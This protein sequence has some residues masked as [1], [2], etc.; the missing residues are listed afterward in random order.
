[1]RLDLNFNG[2]LIPIEQV[3]QIANCY[4]RVFHEM[5]EHP[6]TSHDVEALFSRFEAVIVPRQTGDVSEPAAAEP[7]PVELELKTQSVVLPKT[8]ESPHLDQAARTPME[9]LL[10]SMWSHV[11]KKERINP[12][13]NFFI[14]GGDSLLATQLM[15][16]VRARLKID[17]PLPILFEE[18]PTLRTFAGK[19]EEALRSGASLSR[20]PIEPVPRGQTF[21]LSFAQRRLWFVEHLEPTAYNVPAAIR[22][23][24]P[25][26]RPALKRSLN[27]IVRRHESL[28]TTFHLV[29]G[30]PVQRIA[31]SLDIDVPVVDLSSSAL[32]EE[33]SGI[34]AIH[35]D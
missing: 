8:A 27:E 30:E 15:L 26:D 16:Y 18:A 31:E 13:D 33:R 23:T 10:G 35:S 9:E 29:D 12:D 24:G 3:Q 25:L 7:I 4:T 14:C 19:V 21:P 20:P 17:L 1:M 32:Q 34:K 2:A 11:L 6:D 5:A 28:R 22:I